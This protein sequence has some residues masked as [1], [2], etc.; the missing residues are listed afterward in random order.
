M[1]STPDARIGDISVR[2][3]FYVPNEI[4]ARVCNDDNLVRSALSDSVKGIDKLRVCL[5][6]HDERTAVAIELGNQHTL[7]IS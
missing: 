1:N 4:L 7:I 5:R 2:W 3:P 6:V